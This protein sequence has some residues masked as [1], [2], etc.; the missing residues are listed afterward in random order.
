MILPIDKVYRIIGDEHSWQIQKVRTRTKDG[1][2]IKIWESFKWL[3]SIESA[4]NTLADYMVRTSDAQTLG[5][6]LK[7]VENVTTK[8]S[9][10][11]TM[12]FEVIRKVKIDDEEG[13]DNHR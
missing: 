7:V 3:T 9:L 4:I 5:E 11:L 2:K 6:A 13:N 12:K 1:E 8:L 10:A